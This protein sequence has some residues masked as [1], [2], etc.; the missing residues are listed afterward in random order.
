MNPVTLTL[1]VPPSVNALYLRAKHGGQFKHPKAR[2]YGATVIPLVRN[3]VRGRLPYFGERDVL[4]HA[5]WYRAAG[6]RGD[7]D[8][9]GKVLLDSLQT[10]L[11]Q[12]DGQ[13]ADWRITRIVTPAT[14][15]H[16]IVTV[17]LFDVDA[18]MAQHLARGAA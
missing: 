9:L 13:V 1:P 15:S 17:A 6:K 10:L 11:Y 8:N 7:G 12:N 3:A 4:V 18:F 14:T 5:V 16:L 2:A